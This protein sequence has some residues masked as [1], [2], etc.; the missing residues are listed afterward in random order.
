M[1]KPRVLVLSGQGINCAPETRYC[2]ELA[3]ADAEIRQTGEVLERPAMLE[4]YKGLA[5]PGGFPYAD[6][7]GAGTVLALE[8]QLSATD[9]MQDFVDSGKPVLGICSGFQVL[10]RAGLLPGGSGKQTVSLLPN[11]T[12]RFDDR[13]I[14][15]EP[16]ESPCI[17]THGLKE[18]LAEHFPDRRLTLPIRHGEGRF[19]TWKKVMAGL[20]KNRQVV[21]RYAKPDSGR[22][23]A[24]RPY[25]PNGSL[26]DVAGICNRRGTV[27]GLMPHP[28]GYYRRTQHPR[29]TRCEYKNLPEEGMGMLFFRNAVEYASRL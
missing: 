14:Y 3:G 4:D 18:Y 6:D 19:F 10:V 8:L 23:E 25:N 27:F 22:L 1:A 29:W 20:K 21:L 7:L 9:E 12:G 17:F 28:E 26:G 16:V 11:N 5:I 2:F 24:G 15:M 13:W